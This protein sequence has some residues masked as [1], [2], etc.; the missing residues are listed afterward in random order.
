MTL[1]KKKKHKSVC[2]AIIL[3]TNVLMEGVALLRQEETSVLGPSVLTAFV[4]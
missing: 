3:V 1:N 4:I 2:R